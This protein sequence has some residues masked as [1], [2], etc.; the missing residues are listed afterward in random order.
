MIRIN[1]KG[2]MFALRAALPV[3]RT[4][5]AVVINGSINAHIGMPG[6]AVYAAT[7]GALGAVARVAAAE[8]APRGIRVNVLSP[9]PTDTGVIEKMGRPSDEVLAIKAALVARS[10]QRRLAHPDEIARAALFLACDD[11]SY[12]TGEE[13][14]VDGGMTR[15]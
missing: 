9:G 7:K 3:L 2:P 15:V 4:G 12:M 5:G 1:V 11:S 6:T 14:V 8:F 13:I 10:P